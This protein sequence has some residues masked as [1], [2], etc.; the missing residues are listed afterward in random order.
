MTEKGH[1]RIT[2]RFCVTC[3][4]T[5]AEYLSS[6]VGPV[7]FSRDPADKNTVCVECLQPC[8]RAQAHRA[9]KVLGQTP[10]ARIEAD[11]WIDT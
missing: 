9:I 1:L 8:L 4:A 11:P 7:L 2:G 3:A 10:C 5:A 6:A